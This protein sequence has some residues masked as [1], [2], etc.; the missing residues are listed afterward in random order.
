[1]TQELPDSL[2]KCCLCGA[3]PALVGTLVPKPSHQHRIHAPKGKVGVIL[4]TLCLNCA[5]QPDVHQK[6]EFT[7]FSKFDVLASKQ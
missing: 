4:Y 5:A 6:V 7:I 1:M 3:S 2:S